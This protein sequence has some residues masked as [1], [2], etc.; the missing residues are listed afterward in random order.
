MAQPPELVQLNPEDFEKKDRELVARL[1]DTVNGF[2]SA[3]PEVFNRGLTFGENFAGETRTLTMTGGQP[4]TFRYS[5]G[6]IPRI[7]LVGGFR[8]L[9]N[10]SE[11]LSTAVSLPQWSYD[12][13]GSIT[14]QAI[15][16]LTSGQKYAIIFTITRG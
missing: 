10:S 13:R 2:L 16:G 5:G 15:P 7:L 11:I 3:V 4:L 12:G 9:D 6:G 1:A 14:V 8:N